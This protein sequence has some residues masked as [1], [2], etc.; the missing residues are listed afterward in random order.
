MPLSNKGQ[1]GLHP[2]WKRRG[3]RTACPPGRDKN[4]EG[5]MSVTGQVRVWVVKFQILPG[6][7]EQWQ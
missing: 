6:R 1:P 7:K 3:L 4:R 5:K 2:P